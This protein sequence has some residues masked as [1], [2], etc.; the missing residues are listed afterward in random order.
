MP[1]LV[2]QRATTRERPREAAASTR[3]RPQRKA[4]LPGLDAGELEN[5]LDHLGQPPPFA[6]HQLAVLADLRVVVH[7]AVGEVVGGRADDGQRRPQLVRDGRDEL[8]LLARQLLRAARGEDEK[9]DADA[10]DAEDAGADEQVAAARPRSTA[11][12]SDPDGCFTSR[13]QS[14]RAAGRARAACTVGRRALAHGRLFARR[15]D[16]GRDSLRRTT[17]DDGAAVHR[18][19][20]VRLRHRSR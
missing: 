16:S 3:D 14:R 19:P 20:G 9:A 7:H 2:E 15:L 8:H 18:P 17:F 4:A 12:S 1:R 10:E 11:A 6:A 13:R 5:L